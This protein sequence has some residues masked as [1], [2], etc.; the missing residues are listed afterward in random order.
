MVRPGVTTRKPR[1]NVLAAGPAHGVDG[2]PGDEHGHDGGLA[3]AGGQLQRQAHQLG[4]GVVVGVGQVVEEA[5][6]GLADCGRDLGQPDGGLDRLDLAE[7]RPDAAELV[8]PPVLE[9]A[10][11]FGRDLPVVRV[12]QRPP[13]VHLLA[14]L[15]DDRSGVVL[16]LLRWRAPCPRRRRSAPACAAPLR[17]LRLGDRRDELGAAAGF[18]DLLGRL[19]VVVELPV[20]ARVLVGRVEDRVVEEGIAHGCRPPGRFQGAAKAGR[21]DR[22][23]A[24]SLPRA[25]PLRCRKR[26]AGFRRQ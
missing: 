3:G 7:E 15:V 2:L 23:Q 4:V 20:P 19:A 10:G 14:H 26:Y 6:A 21:S 11:G 9:Q 18:D 12:G 17:F 13:L 25:L 8:V 22:D 5:L 24:S 1:V 16:L